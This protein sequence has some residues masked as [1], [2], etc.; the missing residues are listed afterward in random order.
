MKLTE[1]LLRRLPKVSLHDHLDGGLRPATV[2]ELAAEAGWP[3]PA[4]SVDAL[5]AWFYEASDSGSLVRYLSTFE[6]TLAVMQ[7]APHLR[8]V[9]REYVDDLVADG[10]VYAETRWAPEQHGRAGLTIADA[11]R[12]VAEGLAEG[13]DAARAAGRPIV[14]QQLLTSLRHTPPATEVA[15]MTVEL[16]DAGVA[17]FDLAGP[18]D[19]YPPQLFADAFALLKRANH[20]VTIHAGEAY[21]LPSIWEA[22]QVSGAQ[23]IG[24]GVRIVDDIDPVTGRLGTLAALI[25]DQRIPLE[26]CPTSNVQTG[27]C[28]SVADHPIGR[29]VDAGFLVTVNCDNRLMSRTTLSREFTLLSEAFGW[30]LADVERLTVDAARCAFW[31]HGERERLVEQVIRPGFAKVAADAS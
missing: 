31:A 7:T 14:V 21:G 1:D 25:R 18:E 24:H 13:M 5:A 9:A 6:H 19:G 12:A 26:L 22:I 10:V 3:L 16:R 30:T 20:H 27:V 2:L 11:V 23:R 28:A 4:D 15:A 8:R 29:L 17:G